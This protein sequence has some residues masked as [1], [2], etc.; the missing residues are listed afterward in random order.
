M[1]VPAADVCVDPSGNLK[2]PE[3]DSM[4]PLTESFWA[5]DKVPMPNLLLILSQNRE[6]SPPTLSLAVKKGTQPMEAASAYRGEP[7]ESKMGFPVVSL[8][9]R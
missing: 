9:E 1:E 5:G 4:V 2:P 7:R 8:R 3:V 6:S